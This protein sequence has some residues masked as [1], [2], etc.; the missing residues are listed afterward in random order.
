MAQ[1]EP[2]ATCKLTSISCTRSLG[3]ASLAAGLRGRFGKRVRE[4]RK[5]CRDHPAGQKT[6]SCLTEGLT[7]RTTAYD[8]C[9]IRGGDWAAAVPQCQSILVSCKSDPGLLLTPA[10]AEARQRTTL[11][12]LSI[13]ISSV[14][15]GLQTTKRAIWELMLGCCSPLRPQLRRQAVHRAHFP[16]AYQQT[17]ASTPLR[18]KVVHSFN[19]RTPSCDQC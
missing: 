17:V 15:T 4:R 9:I 12:H 5:D 1:D 10:Y 18:A 6:G 16:Q 7:G 11:A 2:T 13:S 19:I 3:L 8:P 14:E